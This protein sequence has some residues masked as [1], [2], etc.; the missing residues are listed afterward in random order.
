MQL[1]MVGLGRMGA[2]LVR[3]LMADGHTCVVYDVNP[4]AV[5]ALVADGATGASSYAD[6]AEKLDAPRAVWVMV[7]AGDITE[8]A[9]AAVAEHLEADDAIID[10]GNSYY[11][12]DIRR[13][14]L[15]RD[16]GIHYLDC[17]TS[18]G[19]F[20]LARGFSLM[21]G[22][23]D[24]ALLQDQ[25]VDPDRV[26]ENGAV[27]LV[28]GHGAEFHGAPAS[29]RSGFLRSAATISPMIDTAISAGLTAPMSS[30]IGAWIRASAEAS[31]PSARMRSSR[32]ACVFRE[33][34]APM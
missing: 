2:G 9:V 1:G 14:A 34:S 28:Y 20:G 24:V 26:R 19:V 27:C 8:A 12:D 21:I 5:A 25:S 15:Y 29:D 23:D 6:L 32:R 11:R 17:G 16:K 10:G 3:R 7:P 31:K 22:G 33:P 4:D 30:P 18:G 13:A